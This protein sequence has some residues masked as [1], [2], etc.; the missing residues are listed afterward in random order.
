MATA[1][2]CGL[3]VFLRLPE[4]GNVKTR[5]AASLGEDAA[6]AIYEEM[7]AITLAMVSGLNIQCYLFYEGGLPDTAVRIPSLHYLSQSN[8]TLGEKMLHAFRI[9]LQ[10]HK[11][12]IIIGSDCPA[13]TAEDINEGFSKLDTYDVIIGPSVDGGYYLLGLKDIIPSIFKN[14]PWSTSTVFNDTIDITKRQRLNYYLLRT[15]T[16]IDVADDWVSF[17]KSQSSG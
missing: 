9:V 11:K 13:V 16:D 17:K 6:L 10:E 1:S 14:I 3:I 2:D 7:S 8:G 5:I 12:A 15:L 4:K